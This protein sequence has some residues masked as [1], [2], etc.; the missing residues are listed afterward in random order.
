M[1]IHPAPIFSGGTGRS[2][3]TIIGK[4]LSRHTKV[5]CGHPYEIKFM[6]QLFSLTDLAYGMRSHDKDEISINSRLYLKF[7]SLNSYGVRLKKF[8]ARMLGDWYK[9]SNRLGEE[10]GLHRGVSESDLKVLLAD[11]KIGAKEDL[12][13]A[14]R[15]FFRNF[16][17]TQ[18]QYSG[19]PNWMDTSPPNIA[20]AAQIYRLLPDAKFI[21]MKR[22]PLDT[23]SSVMNEDWGP[24]D[25]ETAVK[26]WLRRTESASLALEKIPQENKLSI[27]LEDLVVH[28]REATYMKILEFLELDDEPGVRKYFKS[29]MPPERMHEDRW[30]THFPDHVETERR[31]LE[32]SQED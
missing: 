25:F 32:L 6:T 20:N 27:E 18:N 21:E 26:W 2:G 29:K 11:L 24:N 7:R 3:T 19:Q 16:V 4:L 22:N 31:F 13:L 15:N 9:R 5:K 17:L 8:E 10:S 12:E 28:Q 1:T 23:I 30:K 14:C